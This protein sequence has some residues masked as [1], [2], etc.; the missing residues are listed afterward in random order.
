MTRVGRAVEKSE[1]IGFM[2]LVVDAGTDAILGAAFLGTSG[3]EA[4]HTV[5][6][7]MQAGGNATTLAHTMH[8]HPT[9][10][11]LVPTL[12]GELKP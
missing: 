12:A 10:C 6:D 1:T 9:V 8:I 5:L 2:K 3:D 4:I 7:I 11:E